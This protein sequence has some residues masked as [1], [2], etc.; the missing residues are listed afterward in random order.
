LEPGLL[1][2]TI[3]RG[4]AVSLLSAAALLSP[5]S[6][7]AAPAKPAS[8][9]PAVAKPAAAKP[10]PAAEK[11]TCPIGGAAFTYAVKPAAP[12]IGLRPDGKPYGNGVYP[13]ALPECPD[14]GLILYKDYSAE[15]VEKLTP[16]VASESYQALRSETQYYRAYWLM[17]AMGV[18]SGRYLLALLEAAW[19][20]DDRPELRARYLAEFAEE[21]AKVAPAPD[22]M[23]WIGMEGRAINALRE[24][25][26]FDDAAARLRALSLDAIQAPVLDTGTEAAKRAAQVRQMW[27]GYFSGLKAAIA[28]KDASIEPFDM[29]PRQLALSWCIDRPVLEANQ[30]AF[31]EGEKQAV[32]A[33]KLARANT[34]VD[35]KTLSRPRSES[36]R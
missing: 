33:M 26:R 11:M 5:G 28:R 24:L 21:S 34:Q 10:A 12:G 1:M 2:E 18:E 3:M 13:T 17:K 29:V 36:G 14:N 15:E 30:K 27:L 16:L 19:Q 4:F 7:P 6:A 23:N 25:G 22:D 35:L 20:A 9:K 8:A 32:D 31:C